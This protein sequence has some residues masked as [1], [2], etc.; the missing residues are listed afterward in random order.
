MPPF[1]SPKPRPPPRSPSVLPAGRAARVRRSTRGALAEEREGD[2]GL[3]G[4]E[5]RDAGERRQRREGGNAIPR[6][7]AWSRYAPDVVLRPDSR[8]RTSMAM[9]QHSV[10][11]RS[12]ASPRRPQGLTPRDKAG[13][14]IDR[15]RELVVAGR[16][17]PRCLRGRA[18]RA[19]ASRP[20]AVRVR[21]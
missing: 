10:P 12:D 19:S 2:D 9:P 14:A 20:A 18:G 5:R 4:V 8:S 15:A 11:T 1:R 21:L 13:P 17:C 6:P 16:R 3:A 7:H